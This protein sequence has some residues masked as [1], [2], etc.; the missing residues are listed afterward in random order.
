MEV[1]QSC[2]GLLL[3][4]SVFILF[5]KH[6]SFWDKTLCDIGCMEMYVTLDVLESL[7]VNCMVSDVWKNSYVNKSICTIYGRTPPD[8]R[9][10]E[11]LIY[12]YIYI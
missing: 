5:Y 9:C 11:E 1:F 6:L 4:V 3:W 2:F 7:Y 8:F 10:M 12:I